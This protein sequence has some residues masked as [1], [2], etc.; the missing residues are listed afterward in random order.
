MAEEINAD[1]FENVLSPEEL[2]AQQNQ[3][4]DGEREGSEGEGQGAGDGGEEEKKEIDFT[5]LSTELGTD[6]SDLSSL[7]EDLTYK[8]KYS[9]VEARIA[10]LEK[11]NEDLSKNINY[12]E[13]F[14]DDGIRK[15]NE[16]KKKFPD[17]LPNIAA[18]VLSMDVDK[19]SKLDVIA[20]AELVSTPDTDSNPTNEDIIEG[21]FPGLSNDPAE[22][23]G[24]EKFKVDKAAAIARKK[25]MEMQSVE[26]PEVLN[27]EEMQKQR[28]EASEEQKKQLSQ[29]LTPIADSLFDEFKKEGAKISISDGKGGEKIL[30]TYLVEDSFKES[31]MK[32]FVNDLVNSG[33]DLKSKE[34]LADAMELINEEYVA[35]NIGKILQDYG[36]KITTELADKYHFEV[37]NDK[38]RNENEAPDGEQK[39]YDEGLG[40]VILGENAPDDFFMK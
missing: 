1:S 13:I 22:W 34:D 21:L 8:S 3:G 4:A 27:L 12:K 20:L 33:V 40:K 16:I 32:D 10:E 38:G 31:Y 28:D 18:R 26:L 23:T 5:L 30:H 14:A 19:A 11:K 7:K 24:A 39:E 29:K 17:V 9:E 35:K 2:E 6:Y 15:L 36:E 25:I 37:H